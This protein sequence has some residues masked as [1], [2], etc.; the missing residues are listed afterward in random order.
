MA[1]KASAYQCPS[2]RQR[3]GTPLS[4]VV[5]AGQKLVKLVCRECQFEWPV[6]ATHE[7]KWTAV[8]SA[9]LAEHDTPL[10]VTPTRKPV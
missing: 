10:T 7:A 3:D 5:G 8:P 2:C 9:E 6:V 4:V 1:D